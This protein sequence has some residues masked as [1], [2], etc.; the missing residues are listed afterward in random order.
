MKKK[1]LT[2]INLPSPFLWFGNNYFFKRIPKG[3]NFRIP[4][5]IFLQIR[6]I[7]FSPIYSYLLKGKYKISPEIIIKACIFNCYLPSEV[8]WWNKLGV[9]TW[10]KLSK[11]KPQLQSIYFHKNN[12]LFWDSQCEK[13]IK[14]IFD[15]AL[16][17]KITPNIWKYNFY[18]LKE[19]KKNFLDELPDW[20]P[21][22]KELVIKPRFGKGSEHIIYLKIDINY[23]EYH[24]LFKKNI[25]GKLSLKD[26][27]NKKNYLYNHF[28]KLTGMK[29]DLLIMPYINHSNELPSLYAPLV[30]RVITKKQKSSDN[31]HIYSAWLE[32]QTSSNKCIVSD[33]YGNVLPQFKYLIKEKEAEF[34]E[35]YKIFFYKKKSNYIIKCVEA[36][37][38]MHKIFQNIDMVAW[39]WIPSGEGP[40]LLEGN[41]SFNFLIPNTLSYLKTCYNF[42]KVYDDL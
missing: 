30:V 29:E 16:V 10:E 22:C 20:L 2:L 41:T 31:F 27:F 24:Y 37:C 17:L 8:I 23:I 40:K 26:S 15:K 28:A 11:Q 6:W 42:N 13:E 19:N 12:R 25:S 18:I 36:S 5:E 1:I 14:F 4:F 21:S 34:L 39:D 35:K 9:S 33:L 38:E 7:C 3:S 32:I